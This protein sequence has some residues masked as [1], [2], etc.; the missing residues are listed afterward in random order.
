MSH[1]TWR[2]SA[3]RATSTAAHQNWRRQETA[4]SA[5]GGAEPE[6][7][8]LTSDMWN[9]SP[10]CPITEMDGMLDAA[11]HAA[12][13]RPATPVPY[14][15]F[16]TQ[17]LPP[18][19]QFD[20]WR[21]SYSSIFDLSEPDT[22]AVGFRGSHS[23]WDIGSLIFSHVSTEE[24]DFAGLAGH[25]RR[26]PLDHWLFTLLLSGNSVTNAGGTQFR[27][28]AETV[29][30]HALGRA[31]EGRVSNSE[32]L[33][34]FVPRDLCRDEV[35]ALDAAAFSRLDSGMARI[36]ADYMV[37]LVQQLPQL[38]VT[39][40]TE[41]VAATRAMLLASVEPSLQR[42]EEADNSIAY[43]QLER[44][45]RYIQ[46]HLQNPTL[47]AQMLL[48]ALGLSRSRLYRLFETA[49]GVM[50][51]IQRRRLAAAH[52]AL[53]DPTDV[54]RILDIAECYC[55][56]DA[57]QFS[58][59]FRREF[60]YSPSDVRA[61]ASHRLPGAGRPSQG[62]EDTPVQRLNGLLRRLQG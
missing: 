37:S 43:L 27:G 8:R 9:D 56:G 23:V 47:D 4:F 46:L 53:A 33:M 45:R 7:S 3:P 16:S 2:G 57:A 31:F 50:H 26:E 14:F 29:Q 44:A 62:C 11:P 1:P 13:T 55:F 34:L 35:Q 5:E 25:H 52:A 22:T 48:Q 6:Q 28:E 38:D 12:G 17:D 54:R 41:L 19:E 18:D 58:R 20:G 10:S 36:F 49:D 51:Y 59:A 42:L 32:I 40:M 15:E 30:M 21:S 39:E 60:G 24:V 61:D